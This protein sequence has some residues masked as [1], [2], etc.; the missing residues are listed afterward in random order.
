MGK[1]LMNTRDAI[2]ELAQE[3]IQTKGYNS[4][5]Y[6]D[7]S[8]RL[9]IKRASIHYYFSQKVDLGVAVTI[10]YTDNFK[11]RLD[12][13]NNDKTIDFPKKIEQYFGAFVEISSTKIK[14][15][16][17]GALGGEYIV[18]PELVQV[19]V[20][21]FFDIN[22]LFLTK[23]LKDGQKKGEFFLSDTPKE[24]AYLIFSRL[25]GGLI[26]TRSKNKPKHY[27]KLVE[28]IILA[29]TN[30]HLPS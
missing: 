14:I 4:F 11:K 29:L 21:K 5:S 27:I 2:L 24:V 23:L 16:L 19:E 6:G 3:L 25:E 12:I 20:Q 17:G 1:I 26:I 22:L 30:N 10:R 8:E 28:S 15:C 18:L 13:I 9:G 7:I